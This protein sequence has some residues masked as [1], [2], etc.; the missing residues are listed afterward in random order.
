MINQLNVFKFFNKKF[1]E[2]IISIFIAIS[3]FIFLYFLYYFF[4]IE[5]KEKE[6]SN[7]IA[8]YQNL[9]LQDSLK[10][11]NIIQ[12]KNII[13]NYPETNA[14]KLAYYYIGIFYFKNKQYK[15]ALINFKN[16]SSKDEILN[17]V[18]EGA[19]GDCYVQLNNKN[20]ALFHLKNAMNMTNNDFVI[21]FFGKKLGIFLIELKKYKEALNY[22]NK[23][24]NKISDKSIKNYPEIYAYIKMLEYKNEYKK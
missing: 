8:L 5:P 17:A 20:K 18:N 1:K 6:A 2:I 24:K 13:K 22:F 12:L 14:S 16:F 7:K 3:F 21:F 19:I 15:K 4:L 9:F 11:K 10:E 23:I